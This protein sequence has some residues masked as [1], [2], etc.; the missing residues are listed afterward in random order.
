ML[1]RF[2]R[3]FC[4]IFFVS[5]VLFVFIEPC[6]S[7][8]RKLRYHDT[9]LVYV[10][11]ELRNN[12]LRLTFSYLNREEDQRIYWDKGSVDC[13]CEVYPIDSYY[14]KLSKS[15][16]AQKREFFNDSKDTIFVDMPGDFSK[17]YD[18]GLVECTMQI[19]WK[20]LEVKEKFWVY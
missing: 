8:D 14:N 18:Y 17:N 7:K 4:A 11:P 5:I 16:V 19:G 12:V 1:N 3:F 9:D 10:K 6:Q 13:N 15:P 2:L 20:N